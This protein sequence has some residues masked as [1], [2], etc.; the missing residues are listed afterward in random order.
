MMG[1]GRLRRFLNIERPRAPGDDPSPDTGAEESARFRGVEGPGT[2]LDAAQ[3]AGTHLDRFRPPPERAPELATAADEVTPF[4]RC[5]GC[6]A[7]SSRFAARCE[8]CGADLGTPAQHAFDEQFRAERLAQAE[9][10]RAE[11]AAFH[12][13]RER[14]AEEEVR[15]RQLLGEALAER[16]RERFEREWG[17]TP[18]PRWRAAA[19]VAAV[20]AVFG[21]AL[22]WLASG[23]P[24]PSLVVAVG[25]ALVMLAPRMWRW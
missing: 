18:D 24:G 19:L 5:A 14:A 7:D 11:A 25:L 2:D 23:R 15:A 21:F 6:G 3:G 8:R 16:E 20:A 4:I 9:R 10:D 1:A 12:A 22:F 13:A 17:R